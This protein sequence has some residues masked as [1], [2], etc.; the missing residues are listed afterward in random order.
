MAAM[1]LT[2]TGGTVDNSGAD[3]RVLTEFLSR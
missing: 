1:F 3:Y 2:R